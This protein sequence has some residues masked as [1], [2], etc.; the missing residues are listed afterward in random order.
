MSINNNTKRVEVMIVATSPAIWEAVQR[1]L[2][3]TQHYNSADADY[4]AFFRIRSY[5][6]GVR[7]SITHIAKVK[8]SNNNASVKEYFRQNPDVLSY[9]EI[10]GKKWEKS[11]CHREYYLEWIKP[12][13]RMIPAEY[14]QGC[15][16]QVKLYTTMEE[17]SRATTLGDI[18]TVCQIERDEEW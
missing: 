6:D 14:G 3:A 10:M 2:I 18:R 1:D 16:C 17:L 4:I 12:L 15:R 7:S 5:V 11:E 13:D 8:K 9:S